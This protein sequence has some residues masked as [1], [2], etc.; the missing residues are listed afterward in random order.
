MNAERWQQIEDIFQSVADCSPADR[1]ALLASLCADDADLRGEVESLLAAYD[2]GSFTAGSA[3]DTA[4]AVLERRAETLVEGGQIGA[5]RIIRQIGRGGMGT[6]YLAARADDS[7][8][9]L[10]AIKLIRR[11][12]DSED[13]I[14]H[15]RSERQILATLDHP[16]ITRLLDGGTTSDGLP[17]FV[18][19][20]I[21]GE[22]ID[23][24]CDARELNIT[25][26]LKLFR[27]V[28][29]AVRYAHQNLVIHRD[30]KPGNVL[31]TK[32]G[33]PR[34][35][36]FGIAKLL[37]PG[38][39]E[40]TLTSLRP[41]TPES[42]SPEQVRGEPITTASDI[43]SLGVLLYG[44][45]T[46]HRP[47]RG[48]V[49][50]PAEIERAI[51]EE[52]PER[53]SVVVMGGIAGPEGGTPPDAVSRVRE[54]TPDKLRRRLE[55]D[56]DNIVLMA[57]RKE[58]QRRYAS[59][60]QFSEDISRHLRNLPVIAR[61]DTAGYRAA[62]FVSRNRAEVAAVTLMVSSLVA[63]VLTTSWQARVAS[64][65]RGRAQRQFND[66]RKLATS[67]LFEFNSAIQS[68][69]G[70]TPAR[71][72]LVQRALEYLSKLAQEAQADA[73][74]QR[75]LAEAYLKVGDVQGNPYEP[76]LGDTHG[77]AQSY[78]Q[79]LRISTALVQAHKE[80]TRGRRYLARS[81]QSLGEVLP[82][83]GKPTEGIA[84]LRK[85]SEIFETLAG[86]SP[87]DRELR[88]QLA[89]C[90]ESLGDL[91][92]H[93]GLQNLGDRA[94][95]VESYHKSL[96][97]FEALAS[98][99][100]ND[101]TAR[102][103]VAVLR[104]RIGDMQQAQGDL[105]AAIKNYRAA[106]EIA[107][108][109]A[110]VESKNDRALRTLA[111]SYRKLGD[112]QNQRGDF[113]QAL[114]ND[115]KACDINQALMAADPDNAQAGMNFVLSLTS[116]GDLLNRTGDRP[117]ALVKY[118]QA[119]G[120]LERLSTAAPANL[121]IRGRLAEVLVSMGAVLAQDGRLVEAQGATSRG[122]AIARELAGRANATPDEL[123]LYALSLLTCQPANLRQ[124][125]TAMQSAKQAVEKSGGRDPKSLDILAQA[126][127]RNG[128]IAGAIEAEEKALNLLPPSELHGAAWPLRQR[129]DA[130]LARFRAG[131]QHH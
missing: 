73:G 94:G 72:L 61:P 37:A 107:A 98:R 2:Q 128:D 38:P 109:V 19:E 99:D 100:A 33:M 101:R 115:L 126:Y 71:K 92:G 41:L 105:D 52:E 127:F 86:A 25:E 28:C 96:A 45:L 1:P 112:A 35:L 82:L 120:I 122:L 8:Q 49:S 102:R 36:D 81:Y 23:R 15:F 65:E 29:A 42:A 64:A 53:P 60:E 108:R 62:K 116:T 78:E 46:G 111:L 26:R 34:L 13:V 123:S 77:A 104:I 59:A 113:K 68:L 39:G 106:Q 55:G 43:Y 51:C 67:F 16:N 11:G 103:G 56:L 83:L 32:E 6:V 4:V 89:N 74:L 95:A 18:M 14:R 88:L 31:V 57:L 75:E 27:S 12:L 79:A 80:D 24:Y 91:Q 50:S 47:Y 110:S 22:P 48:T 84:N 130:Q 30:I 129:F 97:V 85:A 90:Y 117:A 76:N 5:Y 66:V 114:E 63:G 125:A 93:S 40:G 3:F 9:K 7:F 10:V 44:L 17:Y 124:P 21:E 121:F 58:P 69:P 118:R 119:V 87:D 20:Y 70:A 131:R 54:G